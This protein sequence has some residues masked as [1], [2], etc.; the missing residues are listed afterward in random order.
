MEVGS[1]VQVG[2]TLQESHRLHPY[3]EQQLVRNRDSRNTWRR[4]AEHRHHVM[5]LLCDNSNNGCQ[6]VCVWGAGNANDLD[7]NRLLD[8]FSEVH[9]VDLDQEALLFAVEQ[10]SLHE[11]PTVV[12]HGGVDL[13]GITKLTA[14]PSATQQNT[15][16]VDRLLNHFQTSVPP[17]C[18]H[19]DVVASVCLLSQLIEAIA[20]IVGAGHPRLPELA[21]A[22]R[23]HHVQ[24]LLQATRPGGRAILVTEILSSDT[25]PTLP[26]IPKAGLRRALAQQI[27]MRNF[28]TG[29]NPAILESL[30]ER[31][32]SIGRLCNGIAAHPPWQWNFGPRTYAVAAYEARTCSQE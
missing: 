17:P 21:T 23:C 32:P 8:V 25:F 9:L 26:A 22:V 14:N 1:H 11:T 19:C 30:A 16:D 5:R 6:S 7:L 4:Y 20:S 31:E 13:L 28:Y 29:L 3:A 27:N 18:E 2:H 10:Q 12:L 24:R 15:V